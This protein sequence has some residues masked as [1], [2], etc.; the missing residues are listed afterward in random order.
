V[1]ILYL[2]QR[3]PYPPDRGDRIA[4]FFQIRH[5][6]KQHEVTIASLAEPGT[7]DRARELAEKLGVVVLAPKH[8]LLCKAIGSLACLLSGKPLTLGY[9]SNKKLR[10]ELDI[11]LEH[12]KYDLIIIFSS[13]MAQYVENV[14]HIPQIMNFCDVDSQKWTDMSERCAGLKRWVYRREGR[15]LLSYEKKL[16]A[17]F[18]ASCFVTQHEADLFRKHVPK[19]P[20]HVIE[21]GVDFEY[22]SEMPRRRSGLSLIFVGVMDYAP[23]EEAVGYFAA[24]IWNKILDVHPDARFIIVGSSPSKN[25]QRLA[26][27]RGIEVTGRVPDIRPY[28]ASATAMIA[29]LDIA[30]GV[31]NK[32]LEAMAAGLPVL[33]TPTVAKGLPPSARC[34]I[35]IAEREPSAFGSAL[36]TL[37]AGENEREEKATA[38]Q[39]YIRRHGSWKSKLQNLDHLLDEVISNKLPASA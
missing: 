18:N 11:I 21:N 39:D 13:S 14:R 27:T 29:P 33:V 6:R 3:I 12:K 37:I 2:C 4:V 28:L 38:A 26:Q 20:V 31:Q 16:A 9:Y 25:V 22:F 8:S 5:L 19:A 1:K 15:L 23:N 32:I 7:Q 10:S 35:T 17:D 36:L 34:T 24:N 30:R